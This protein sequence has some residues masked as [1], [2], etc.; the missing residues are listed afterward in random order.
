VKA[1]GAKG[2]GVTDDTAAIQA[3]F[4]SASASDVVYFDHGAYVITST[5]KVPK[6]IRITG[7]I[8]PL[9]MAGGSTSF[10][11]Q[12]NP[13][14]VFQVGQPGDVGSVEMSDLIFE[15]LGPQPGAILVEWNVAE[16]S[17]GSSGI[18]DVHMRIGGSAGTQLQ[19]NTCGKNPNVTAAANPSC[20]GAFLL[21][22]ITSQATAYVENCWFW[23][24]VS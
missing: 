7:E 22:H 9:I 2:D 14:P 4:D 24:A 8:W 17:Q 16:S 1:A 18:W 3:L 12:A 11:S 6:D 13:A 15:T 10:Q 5:V 20:E 19:S 23:V 21:L